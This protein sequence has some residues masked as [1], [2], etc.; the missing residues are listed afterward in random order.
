[1]VD[2]REDVSHAS[3][4]SDEEPSAGAG[5]E[6]GNGLQMSPELMLDLARKAAELLVAR[7]ESL[8]G[9][10]A[11]EGDFREALEDRLME[12]PPEDSQEP[13]AVLEQAAREI[14]P[15]AMRLDHPRSF[16]FVPTAPTWPGVLADF[17]AAGYNINACTW[18]VASGPSQLEL[19]VI[20]WFRRWLGYPKNAG[21]LFT[22]GGSAASVD[23]ARQTR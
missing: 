13:A 17:L 16:A 6:A 19:V 20:D 15:I 4:R 8:P 23:A 12:D 9:E 14:L 10:N 5:R 22:S 2:Q 7:I 1:M 21:G 18:L 3:A 11:W